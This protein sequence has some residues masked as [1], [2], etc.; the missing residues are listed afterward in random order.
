M[1]R[2]S[3]FPIEL[4]RYPNYYR[5]ANCSNLAYNAVSD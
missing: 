5:H 4:S 3:F 2:Y 1:G